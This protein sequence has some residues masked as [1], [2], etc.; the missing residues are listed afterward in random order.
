MAGFTG[1]QWHVPLSLP[2]ESQRESKWT[3][4]ACRYMLLTAVQTH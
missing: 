3:D 2:L 1:E 4:I